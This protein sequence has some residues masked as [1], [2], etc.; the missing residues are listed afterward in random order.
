MRSLSG[1]LGLM[2]HLALEPDRPINRIH[3]RTGKTHSELLLLVFF[4][5]RQVHDCIHGVRCTD[6]VVKDL[7]HRCQH[8][9]GYAVLAGQADDHASRGNPLSHLRAGDPG[10]HIRVDV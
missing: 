8:G 4:Y 6:V 2:G 10:H 5:L 7:G 3:V 1:R 9:Q